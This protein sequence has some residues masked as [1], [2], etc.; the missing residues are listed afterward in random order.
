VE[1]MIRFLSIESNSFPVF[2]IIFHSSRFVKARR[3]TPT[4]N[5]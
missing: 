5:A 1:R 3:D 4:G 2:S